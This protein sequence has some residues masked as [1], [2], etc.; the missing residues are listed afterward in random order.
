MSSDDIPKEVRALLTDCI[1]SVGQLELLLLVRKDPGRFWS[2][3]DIARELRT[4]VKWAEAELANLCR[5]GFLAATGAGPAQ[6]RYVP[7]TTELD[8]A[9]AALA[10][11]YAQRRVTITAMIFAKPVDKLRT[12]ADAFR[13]RK[14]ETDD[15]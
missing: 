8:Q 9:V 10:T 15:R 7:G 12:F 5:A 1:D 11:C 2:A 14:E 6:Y 13:F 4:G 3:S